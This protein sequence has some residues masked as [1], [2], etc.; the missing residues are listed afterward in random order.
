MKNGGPQ[1]DLNLMAKI[2]DL[3]ELSPV[4]NPILNCFTFF[5]ALK[6]PEELGRCTGL[7]GLV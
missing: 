5:L 3:Q 7:F 1:I 2:Y 4:K 6:Y